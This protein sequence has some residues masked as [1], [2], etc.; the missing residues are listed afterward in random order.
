MPARR[1]QPAGI[2]TS[3]Y[4]RRAGVHP[5]E[6]T[7]RRRC[8]GHPPDMS[9]TSQWIAIAA[10][11]GTVGVAGCSTDQLPV[12]ESLAATQKS[13]DQLQ[14]ANVGENGLAQ[15]RTEMDQLK[16]NLDQLYAEAKAEFGAE[17]DALRAAVNQFSADL[18]AARATPDATT[19][20]AVRAALTAVQN[21]AVGL[22]DAMS[23]TC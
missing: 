18:A 7:C 23:G 8:V 15:I 10:I 22:R 19:F 17:V 4:R 16:H 12:C 1:A 14:K 2:R 20:A 3:G 13:V 11:M 5:A 21:S 9:R 6:M